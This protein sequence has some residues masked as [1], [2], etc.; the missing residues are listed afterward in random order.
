MFIPMQMADIV[1]LTMSS[2]MSTQAERIFCKQ[3]VDM[4]KLLIGLFILFFFSCST[5]FLLLLLFLLSGLFQFFSFFFCYINFS[6]SFFSF[7]TPT[8]IFWS[9]YYYYSVIVFSWYP[10]LHEFD[11]IQR[12]ATSHSIKKPT[13]NIPFQK[14][15]EKKR[16]P[17][18]R[19]V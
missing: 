5:L 11:I 1:Q 2:A 10:S 14:D 17:I 12:N 16:L 19:R 6:I 15:W 13:Q 3:L 7:C 9:Y 8:R 4:I 18:V